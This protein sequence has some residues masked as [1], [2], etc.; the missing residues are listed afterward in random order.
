MGCA[1]H[2]SVSSDRLTAVRLRELS[3]HVEPP[4]HAGDGAAATPWRHQSELRIL[5]TSWNPHSRPAITEQT[6]LLRRTIADEC[7]FGPPPSPGVTNYQLHDWVE[8]DLCSSRPWLVLHKV[9]VATLHH[10]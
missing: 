3:S 7:C 10:H 2:L 1:A 9:R 4:S 6:M 5:K 8:R